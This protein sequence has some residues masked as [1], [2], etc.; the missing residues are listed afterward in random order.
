MDVSHGLMCFSR[1]SVINLR[2]ALN[3]ARCRKSS[4]R[5]GLSFLGTHNISPCF[6][7]YIYIYIY[8]YIHTHLVY[9]LKKVIFNCFPHLFIE[10]LT[11]TIF[12]RSLVGF[13]FLHST[14]QFVQCYRCVQGLR[15]VLRE[16][17]SYILH[18]ESK[19]FCVHRNDVEF[20]LLIVLESMF[21]VCHRL[22]SDAIAV[23]FCLDPSCLLPLP[24]PN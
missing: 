2:S 21:Y 12:T 14:S 5:V 22:V 19:I 10:V 9:Y 20:R 23:L 18:Q 13:P 3:K 7:L 15:R 4:G 17:L 1:I 16:R 8:I 11:D 6:W 24:S